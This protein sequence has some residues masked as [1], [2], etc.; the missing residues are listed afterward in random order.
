MVELSQSETRRAVTL[1]GAPCHH[2]CACDPCTQSTVHLQTRGSITC[3]A[4]SMLGRPS[5]H[6]C[7]QR[8]AASLHQMALCN[9]MLRWMHVGMTLAPLQV[10][11]PLWQQHRVIRAAHSVL[12]WD[13]SEGDE[14]TSSC[15]PNQLFQVRFLLLIQHC[16]LNLG[17]LIPVMC[18]KNLTVGFRPGRSALCHLQVRQQVLGGSSYGQGCRN[19]NMCRAKFTAGTRTHNAQFS[20]RY[21]CLLLKRAWPACFLMY[22]YI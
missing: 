11:I 1:Q 4:G 5:H 17:C 19:I 10:S 13:T 15:E 16:Q 12:S 14:E 9:F 18:F 22:H 20:E 8:P 6:S 3:T 21:T 7:R 2:L